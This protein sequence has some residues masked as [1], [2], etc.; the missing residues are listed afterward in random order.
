MWDFIWQLIQLVVAV[1]VGTAIGSYIIFD[2]IMPRR[3]RKTIKLIKTELL[4]D[5]DIQLVISQIKTMLPKTPP[6][7]KKIRK[8]TENPHGEDEPC[9]RS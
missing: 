2:I 7:I 8:L 1:T 9:P 5:E 3:I 6:T 4:K